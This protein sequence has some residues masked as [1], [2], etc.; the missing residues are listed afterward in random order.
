MVQLEE[1][2]AATGA[3]PRAPWIGL[4]EYRLTAAFRFLTYNIRKGRGASGKL[5]GSVGEMATAL[6]PQRPDLLLCQEVYHGGE[7]I[8]LLH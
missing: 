2:T 7:L 4:R 5:D 6:R 3:W 8:A 1:T